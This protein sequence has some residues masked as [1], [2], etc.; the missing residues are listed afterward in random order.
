MPTDKMPPNYEFE[1]PAGGK[2]VM[3][4]EATPDGP[5]LYLSMTAAGAS[6]PSISFWVDPVSFQPMLTFRSGVEGLRTVPL[7]KLIGGLRNAGTGS[8]LSG[9]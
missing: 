9:R 2:V 1:F 8:L 5:R 7:D 3:G 4:E 6:E